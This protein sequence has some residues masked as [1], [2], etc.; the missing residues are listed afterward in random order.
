MRAQVPAI[1]RLDAAARKSA[2]CADAGQVKSVNRRRN[3]PAAHDTARLRA[4]GV[5][6][7]KRAANAAGPVRVRA[8]EGNG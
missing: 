1:Y 2:G 3:H 7:C 5:T 8:T 4:A 6:A